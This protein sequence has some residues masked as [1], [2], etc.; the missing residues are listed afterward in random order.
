MRSIVARIEEGL[1]N[2][3]RYPYALAWLECGHCVKVTLRDTTGVCMGCKAIM[4]HADGKSFARCV[5]G[6]WMTGNISSPNPHKAEDR[7]TKIGDVCECENCQKETELVAWLRALPTGSVHHARFDP[8][9]KPGSYHLYRHDQTSPS[10]FFLMGSVPATP[11][12][13]A[14]LREIGV[15]PISPTERA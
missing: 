2:T 5:C 3:G 11:K 4:S 1:T 6:M 9:F 14:V 13:D 7:L 8:R 12:F 10:G 15:S